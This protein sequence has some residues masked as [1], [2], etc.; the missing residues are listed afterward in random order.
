MSKGKY[1]KFDPKTGIKKYKTKQACDFA[2]ETQI[3]AFEL[4]LAPKV[5]KRVDDFSY[6]TE[7]AD[8]NFFMDN[9][10]PNVYYNIIFPEI[11][12]K[13]KLL[14]KDNPNPE[15]WG[16]DGV[17]MARHNLGIYK[18]KVVMIDFY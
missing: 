5:V 11:H 4:G 6:Q 17:D 8:T 18:G 12:K 13:L 15:K 10:K 14:F 3:K 7:L 9:F 1:C 16:P 2:Y